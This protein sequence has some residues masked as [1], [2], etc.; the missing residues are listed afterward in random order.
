MAAGLGMLLALEREDEKGDRIACAVLAASLAFS[1]IGLTFIVGAAVEIALGRRPR[2]RRL[3]VAL[4]P[5]AL[6]AF[7]WVGWGHTAKSNL[8]LHNVEHLPRFVFNAASAGITSL[9]GLATGDGGEPSQPH[10]IWGK[11][12]LVPLIAGVGW[13]I[14]RDRALPPGLPLALALGPLFWQSA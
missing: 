13:R 5:F 10:L 12:L 2:G 3:Y 9:L 4:L 6:Y 8:S 1:S 14:Y 11:V 7:W